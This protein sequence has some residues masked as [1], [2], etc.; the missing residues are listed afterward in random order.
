[1]VIALLHEIVTDIHGQLLA[2]PHGTRSELGRGYLPGCI[3]SPPG[4]NSWQMA[5]RGS[6]GDDSKGGQRLGCDRSGDLEVIVCLQ[7]GEAVSHFRIHFS[8]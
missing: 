7:L 2:A 5:V 4:A 8:V 6:V 3:R 1:M